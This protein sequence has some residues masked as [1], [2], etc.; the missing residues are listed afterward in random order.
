MMDL[1]CIVADKQI[2]AA[3]SGLLERPRALG[4]RPITK[5]ILLHPEH[6][7][8]CFHSP[9]EILRGYRH[10]AEHALII[11]D[12]DWDG[13][14]T[15]SGAD[16]ESGIDE[17]LVSAGMADWA[18]PVVIDPELE[19]WVFGSSPRVAEVLGWTGPASLRETLERQGFW[20]P[21]ALKP[22]D[23]KAA[24][25]H[26]LR[27]TGKSRSASLFR[28]IAQRA[29]TRSC[30]DRAFVRLRTVLQ[31]WFPPGS[32]GRVSVGRERRGPVTG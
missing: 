9:A 24:L 26:V 10:V 12:H 2:R 31:A 14:P 18:V 7:P 5:E 32:S 11:L 21:D 28:R 4:I 25:E 15:T 16:L 13:V 17:K 23:P 30:H 8:G 3:L 29:G 22:A 6:D 1:V 19:A 20:E 27:R